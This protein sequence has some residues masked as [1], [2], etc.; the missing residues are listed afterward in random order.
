MSGAAGRRTC[1]FLPN[2]R[3]LHKKEE[4]GYVTCEHCE[5]RVRADEAVLYEHRLLYYSEHYH[6]RNCDPEGTW[7]CMSHD[8]DMDAH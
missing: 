5:A 7:D 6:C 2:G 4:T 3:K 1:A 8:T